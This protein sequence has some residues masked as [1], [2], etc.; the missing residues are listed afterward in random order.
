MPPDIRDMLKGK[1][2]EGS[3]KV[4]EVK[5]EEINNRTKKTEKPSEIN[6]TVTALI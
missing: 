1:K 6:G 5:L 2:E 3:A 4:S